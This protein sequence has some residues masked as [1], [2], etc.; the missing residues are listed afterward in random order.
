MMEHAH[1]VI[2]GGG[3]VGCALAMELA[4][5]PPK[6]FAAG[7]AP[8]IFLL[9]RM[10]RTGMGASSRN[11]GVIHSGIYY[12]PGSLKARLCVAGNPL[13]HEFCKAHGVAHRNTGKL[14]VAAHHGE[15]HVLEELAAKGRTNGVTGI[16]MIDRAGVHAREPHIAGVA[17]LS[18]P[19]TG[20]VASE[21]LVKAYARVATEHGANIVTRARV[22]SLEPDRDGIRVSCEIGDAENA[23]VQTQGSIERETIHAR[24]VVNCAGLYADE[25]AAM[26]GFTKHRIYPVRGEY[27]ELIRARAD[28]VRGLVYPLPHPEGMSLGV[29]LTRTLWDTVLLGPTARYVS[30]KDDYESDRLKIEDFVEMAK[31]LVPEIRAEDLRLGYSG[32]RAKLVPPRD[33]SGKEPAA[34][35]ADFVITRDPNVAA[36]IHLI[37]IE[38]P[39]LTSALAIARHVA[40]IVAETLQ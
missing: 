34:G 19:S 24:C 38:S 20:I 2:I 33:A 37:G 7:H 15:E 13:T 1:I 6:L 27:C 26:L 12:T 23:A 10:P 21:E 11:S 32:L 36:A 30:E 29:H 25:I 9:E 3:V 16:E 35:A 28:L 17:A 18:I 31:P 39:G 5:H 4:S 8:D 22:T 14:V 40:P